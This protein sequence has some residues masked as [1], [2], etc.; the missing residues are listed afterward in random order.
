M[1]SGYTPPDDQTSSREQQNPI[2]SIPRMDSPVA[3]RP[4]AISHEGQ[5][6][7]ISA[8][9]RIPL[10]GP[11]ERAFRTRT[12]PEGPYHEEVSPSPHREG[13]PLMLS[14]PP[15]RNVSRVEGATINIESSITP[16]IRLAALDGLLTPEQSAGI[17]NLISHHALQRQ[18]LASAGSYLTQL[19]SEATEL[20]S[21]AESLTG[22]LNR[23]AVDTVQLLLEGDNILAAISKAFERPPAHGGPLLVGLPV[24]G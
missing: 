3:P 2:S 4:S 13:Q 24:E 9:S 22:R 7:F 1:S 21:N 18:K 12:P 23:V 14:N 20:R 10:E 5:L 6:P 8:T 15:S 11:I 19:H 16:T 17:K